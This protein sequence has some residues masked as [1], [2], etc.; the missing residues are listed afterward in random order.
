MQETNNFISS[1][2]ETGIF[3]I[4]LLLGFGYMTCQV[5]GNRPGTW[6]LSLFFAPVRNCLGSAAKGALGCLG[7]IF[8]ASLILSQLFGGVVNQK[9][10]PV[11]PPI[12]PPTPDLLVQLSVNPNDKAVVKELAGTSNAPQAFAELH[13]LVTTLSPDNLQVLQVL[14]QQHPMIPATFK[15]AV[16]QRL[17]DISPE[18]G[19]GNC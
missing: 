2:L 3:L 5:F 17:K 16:S 6:L 19:W 11:N 8:V 1:I 14:C 12:T 15:E 10:P 13:G 4:V 7:I 9:R 18:K